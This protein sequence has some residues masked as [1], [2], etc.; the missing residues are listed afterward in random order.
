MHGMHGMHARPLWR[1][2]IDDGLR[3]HLQEGW[4]FYNLKLEYLICK[5]TDAE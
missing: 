4:A 1:M 5:I 2:L 3:M